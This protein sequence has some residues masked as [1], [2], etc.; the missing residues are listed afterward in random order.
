MKKRIMVLFSSKQGLTLIACLIA[1]GLIPGGCGAVAEKKGE[2]TSSAA[3]RP[4]GE[5]RI[6]M[7]HDPQGLWYPVLG[8]NNPVAEKWLK[9]PENWK[10]A[11][12]TI[13][14]AYAEAK[15]DTI[16]HAVFSRFET[17]IRPGVTRVAQPIYEQVHYT[18]PLEAMEKAGVD[19][20]QIMLNQAHKDGLTFIAA[21]RMNDRHGHAYQTLVSDGFEHRARMYY[22]HPEWHLKAAPGGFDYS[23]QGLRDKVLQFVKDV[24]DHYDVDGIEY[25]WLRWV[26]IFPQGTEGRNA[27]LLTEFHRQSRMLLDEAGRK[28]G[29]KLLLGV[30]VPDSLAECAEYGYAVENWIREGLIDY[31]VP[32]GFGH[33]DFNARVEDFRELTESTDC[34]VYPSLNV[35]PGR[36]RIKKWRPENYYAA[37]HNYYGF[38]ADGIAT[39]N[40]QHGTIEERLF[41]LLD[42]TPISDPAVLA[43]QYRD[44]YFWRRDR[45]RRIAR[46]PAEVPHYDV[47]SLWRPVG[48]YGF[49]SRGTFD[50]RLAEDL[51]KGDISAVMEFKAVGIVE[52]DV[53]EVALNGWEIARDRIRRYHVWDGTDW[54]GKPEPYELFRIHL[55]PGD[56]VYGDNELAV[57]LRPESHKGTVDIE[58]LNIKVYPD[59]SN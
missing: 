11:L 40:Y 36:S 14:H 33:M 42:L 51:T 2:A 30:R 20:L 16:S 28:R 6:V 55:E 46:S 8:S 31:V 7:Y 48:V 25:D 18:R 22:D 21:M 44:Y 15:I 45:G 52:G 17:N 43:R 23:K 35:W 29:R 57:S 47:M 50:F 19:M 58:D 53:F 54:Q 56:L 1:S 41:K 9:D 27:P 49:E 34:R 26:F 13:V 12:E 10:K 37:A 59:D 24:I 32:S 3:Y 5:R 39:Y 38:G 4:R